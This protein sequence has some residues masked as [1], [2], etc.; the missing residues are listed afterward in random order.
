V[1]GGT[2][3]VG[4]N[5]VDALPSKGASVVV[6]DQLLAQ[7][8]GPEAWKRRLD[9]CDGICRKHGTEPRL[10]IIDLPVERECLKNVIARNNIDT[11]FMLSAVFGG[12]GFVDEHQVA[13]SIGFA[14][15]QNTI[16]V[17]RCDSAITRFYRQVAMRRGEKVAN[18]A[19]TRKL[20]RAM[21]IMLKNKPSGRMAER[22]EPLR[23]LRHRASVTSW[24]TG[25]RRSHNA[26]ER[27]NRR[28]PIQQT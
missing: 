21:Y 8:V 2:G 19:A 28:V 22:L 11:C 12:R 25:C 5:V 20:M 4:G 16:R 17:R 13:C 24:A 9:R 23:L 7:D 18:V 6:A 26:P 3:F 27:A 10:Q 1:S 14:I 15:D